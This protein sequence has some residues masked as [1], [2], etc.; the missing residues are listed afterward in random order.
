MLARNE[1]K[2]RSVLSMELRSVDRSFD[3]SF[4]GS[5]HR[6]SWIVMSCLAI[7]MIVHRLS[8]YL[9]IYLTELCDYL[10]KILL[11]YASIIT[12]TLSF[13]FVFHS[14]FSSIF[15]PIF[16][17]LLSYGAHRISPFFLTLFLYTVQK[18]LFPIGGFL[19]VKKILR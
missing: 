2:S 8:F 11:A 1:W 6:I 9:F 18:A 13:V 19:R 7:F 14:P 5:T 4:F 15:I 17:G 12:S 16:V 10:S 3:V